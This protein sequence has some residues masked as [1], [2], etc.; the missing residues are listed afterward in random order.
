M[1]KNKDKDMAKARLLADR[2]LNLSIQ[3]DMTYYQIGQKG[4]IPKKTLYNITTLSTKNP[5]ILTVARMCKAFGISM[6]EFCDCEEFQKI[7]EIM[8][9]EV[10]YDS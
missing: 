3:K 8:E 6:A 7:L 5:G 1:G 10:K 4:G 2:I 9:E